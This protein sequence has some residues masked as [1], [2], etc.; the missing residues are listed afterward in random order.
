[1]RPHILQDHLFLL[2][3]FKAA[4]AHICRGYSQAAISGRGEMIRAAFSFAPGLYQPGF[5]KLL[6]H[7]AGVGLG[8]LQERGSLWSGE[9]SLLP[10]GI[11]DKQLV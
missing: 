10:Q 4:A 9:A 11:E 7:G 3:G 8:L 2:D 6:Q 5:Y 1:M